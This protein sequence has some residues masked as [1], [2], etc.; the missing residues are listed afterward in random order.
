[1]SKGA[2]EWAW[3]QEDLTT[4]QKFVLVTIG[5]HYSDRAHYA[6]PSQSTIARLVSATR[7]SVNRAVRALE[8]DHGLIEVENYI[9]PR[10]G[11]QKSSRYYLPDHDPKSH[12]PRSVRFEG[13]DNSD[14]E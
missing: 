10:S 3:E 11:Q 9:D 1:M 7:E 6:W 12:A 2:R 14:A 13:V 4:L 8:L 5:D